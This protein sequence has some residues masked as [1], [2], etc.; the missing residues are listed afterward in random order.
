[1]FKKKTDGQAQYISNGNFVLDQCLTNQAR[2][3]EEQPSML[4]LCCESWSATKLELR[5]IGYGIQLSME[6]G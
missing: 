4:R 1:M 3:G 6:K 2:R 5:E